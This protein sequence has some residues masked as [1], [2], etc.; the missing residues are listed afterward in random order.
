MKVIK[1]NGI[2]ESFNINKIVEAVAKAVIEVDGSADYDFAKSVGEKVKEKCLSQRVVSVEDIQNYVEEILMESNRKD[3][4]RAYVRYRYIKEITRDTNKAYDSILRLLDGSN[5]ELKYENS[6]KNSDVAST[7]RDYMAGEVSKDLTRRTLLPKD[8]V[9]ADEAGIIHFHDK[10]YFAQ[11]IFNCFRGDTKFIS[12]KGVK[13]FCAFQDGESILVPTHT[14]EWK[15]ATVKKYGI[16]NVNKIT[17]KRGGWTEKIIY[18]TS[19]HRWILKDGQLTTNLKV[20]DYLLK[21][22]SIA[23][24]DWEDLTQEEKVVWCYGFAYGDGSF[25]SKPYEYSVVRLCGNKNRY[26]NNFIE[27]GFSVTYPNCFNGDASIIIPGYNKNTIPKNLDEETYKIFIHGLLSAD[28]H[29]VNVTGSN[30]KNEFRGIQVTGSSK[31]DDIS[32][33]LEMAGYYISSED[34][35]TNQITNYGKRSDI[36][37]LFRIQSEQTYRNWRVT[38]IEKNVEE[39]ETWCLEVEDNH[40]FILSGGIVTGNCCLINLE[41][42]LQNGTVVNKTRIDKPHSFS[43]ACNIATQIMACVASGQYGGQSISLSHLA[44]F[45]D[46][47]RKKFKKQVEKELQHLEVAEKEKNELIE[48]ITENRVLE[49]IKRGVQTMQYQINTLNTSNGQTP[50]VSVFMYLNE[51]KD[52]QTKEDLAKIIEEVLK[53]RIQGVKNEKGVYIAPTFPKLI[54]CLEEDNITEDSKYWY[55]TKLAAECTARRMVP[56][57]ISEKIMKKLKLSKGEKEGEGDVYSPMGLRHTSP[58]KTS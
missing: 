34:D 51:V 23:Q 17:L 49:D 42:M 27:A 48:S 52:S 9:E 26:K 2:T 21:T 12:N 56:D 4:A 37:K 13:P 14:G 47:S 50:F 28:G 31:I 30:T 40:S 53:Q 3:I 29:H 32:Q 10:D 6:N 15:K 11:H 54:Y 44:P 18:A 24:Y 35:L 45:V 41:D 20:G 33:L 43:T 36:T 25:H 46:E 55:L 57:Y 58:C 8:I 39:V 22:P 5:K 1:R 16:K 7:Q 19:N 38:S